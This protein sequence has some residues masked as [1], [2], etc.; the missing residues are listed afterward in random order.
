MALAAAALVAVTGHAAGAAQFEGTVAT[1]GGVAITAEAVRVERDRTDVKHASMGR[2]LR[3][4]NAV[5]LEQAVRRELVFLDVRKRNLLEGQLGDRMRA[6]TIPAY[7]RYW[8]QGRENELPVTEQEIDAATPGVFLEERRVSYI[9]TTAEEPIRAAR[10]RALAGEDFAALAR[11]YS[12]GPGSEKGGDLGWLG[13][14]QNKY[15]TDEQWQAIFQVP[16][17]GVTEVFPSMIFGEGFAIARV[18]DVRR[19]S[20]HEVAEMRNAVRGVVREN[21][22]AEEVAQIVRSAR[23]VLKEPTPVGVAKADRT[24]VLAT[25]DGG[26][27]TAGVFRA[28]LER[29]KLDA[30]EMDEATLRLHLKDLGELSVITAKKTAELE[31]RTGFKADVE[32]AYKE[33]LLKA[34]LDQMY[35]SA[36]VT[37]EE[38]ERAYRQHPEKSFLPALVNLWQI[39]FATKAEA[40]EGYARLRKG[41]EFES[42]AQLFAQT[43]EE[44]KSAGHAGTIKDDTFPEPLRSVIF[45]LK[46]MEISKPV[47]ARFGYFV[48]QVRQKTA[49]KQRTLSEM[50]EVIRT[51]LLKA[52]RE[53]VFVDDI[54]RL[55]RIYGV[56]VNDATL[57]KI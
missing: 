33:A 36:A 54:A 28:Y 34:Y 12:E 30:A 4:K 25:F 31:K 20:E 5:A 2:T 48:F 43:P 49:A 42:V 17:G 26:T 6:I 38:V 50:R 22:V 57:D 18:D 11:E 21:K 39:R 32:K 1:A 41:E 7:A 16:K 29:M 47:E 3:E 45:G 40:E 9:V 35:E 14:G 24:A 46:L 55:K 19:Y 37:D 44:R 56:K 13:R 23:L 51:D 10:K 15:F 53:Q 8:R 52:K 27:V